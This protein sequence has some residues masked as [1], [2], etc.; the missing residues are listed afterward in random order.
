MDLFC[1]TLHM[2]PSSHIQGRKALQ[3]LLRDLR[4]NSGLTQRQLAE[5]LEVPPSYVAKYEIGER[6]L[7]LFELRQICTALNTTL[8]AIV[9]QLESKLQ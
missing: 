5:R 4:S 3:Q 1:H 6:K 7:D 9:T 8:A 2:R